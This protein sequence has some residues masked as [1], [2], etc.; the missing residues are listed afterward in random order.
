MLAQGKL[1][2]SNLQILFVSLRL[3][4]NADVVN[5]FEDIQYDTHKALA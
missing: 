3:W 4:T 2:T 5:L 1:K